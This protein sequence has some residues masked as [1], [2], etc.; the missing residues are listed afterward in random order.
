MEAGAGVVSIGATLTGAALARR[1]GRLRIMSLAAGGAVAAP[2]ILSVQPS[3]GFIFGGLLVN[4]MSEALWVPLNETEIAR[5]TPN[6]LLARTRATFMFVTWGALPFASLIGGGL[7]TW[8]GT[9]PALLVAAATACL[10]AL[11]GIWPLSLR[12]ERLPS[13]KAGESM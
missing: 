3:A 7:A 12:P 13:N 6:H 8:L 11:A 2:L 9:R 10:G 5:R 4:A 1:F